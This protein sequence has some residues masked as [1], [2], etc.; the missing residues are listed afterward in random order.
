MSGRLPS[1][2]DT[3]SKPSL[4]FKPKVVARRSKEEREA[5]VPK[6]KIEE[7][8]ELDKRKNRPK[9]VPNAGQKKRVPRYLNNTHVITSGPLAAGNFVADKNSMMKAKIFGNAM[10]KGEEGTTTLIQ[11][12]LETIDNA[13][14]DSDEELGE[15]KETSSAAARAKKFNMGKEL[16]YKEFISHEQEVQDVDENDSSEDS[17]DNMEIDEAR[18]IEQLFPIRP[19]RVKHEDTEALKKAVQDSMSGKTTREPTPGPV[20]IKEEPGLNEDQMLK[21][22]LIKKENELKG[23]LEELRLGAEANNDLTELEIEKLQ[24]ENDHIKILKNIERI[25]NKPNKFMIFQLPPKLPEFKVTPTKKEVTDEITDDSMDIDNSEVKEEKQKQKKKSSVSV[26]LEPELTGNIG[27]IRVHRSGRLSVKIGDVV[28]DISKGAESNFMQD[29]IRFND[30]EKEN[31]KR[32]DDED[33]EP[34]TIEYLGSIV[35]RSVIQ[36]SI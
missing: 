29:I 18:R 28:M 1:L 15:N 26:T 23:K 34:A 30:H 10:A 33:E 4:K 7:S 5:S 3:G 31:I 36:P 9:K 32:E 11:K 19:L 6:V 2:K 14:D 16:T 21:H 24:I 20:L 8:N 12:G 13:H 27:S 17:T 22:E 25:N 35:G